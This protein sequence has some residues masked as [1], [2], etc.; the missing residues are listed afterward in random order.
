LEN[1][2]SE[3]FSMIMTWYVKDSKL[4]TDRVAGIEDKELDLALLKELPMLLSTETKQL[5]YV[6]LDV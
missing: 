2:R 6:E 4:G 5:H 1:N 3:N